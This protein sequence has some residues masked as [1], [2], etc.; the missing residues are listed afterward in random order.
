MRERGNFID[1]PFVCW[2]EKLES[3]FANLKVS[4]LAGPQRRFEV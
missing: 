4:A 2:G 3:G 1:L